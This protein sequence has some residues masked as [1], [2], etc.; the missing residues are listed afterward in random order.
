MPVHERQWKS[1]DTQM[2]LIPKALQVLQITNI[3]STICKENSQQK[4]TIQNSTSKK[5]NLEFSIIYNFTIYK[6]RMHFKPTLHNSLYPK[7][8]AP[9]SSQYK[10]GRKNSIPK[11][12]HWQIIL[13]RD[14]VSIG[15]GHVFRKKI[16]QQML[17]SQCDSYKTVMCDSRLA[18]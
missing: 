17:L 9:K 14:K 18:C 1:N 7:M 10:I 16:D 2:S 6:K 3:Q 12:L 8:I 13:Q 4:V 5:V 11:N 15:E